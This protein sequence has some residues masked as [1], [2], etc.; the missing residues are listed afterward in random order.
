VDVAFHIRRYPV[1][2]TATRWTATR[3]IA[4]PWIGEA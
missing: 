4:T 3:W 2:W 1:W